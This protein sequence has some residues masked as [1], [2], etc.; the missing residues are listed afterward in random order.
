MNIDATRLIARLDIK[1]NNVV[2]GI[3][4]EGIRKV[5]DP[6]IL[7]KKYYD[8]GI[9]EIIYMDSV[10]SLYGRNSLKK[11]IIDAASEIFVPLTVGGG[12]RSLKDIREALNSG[13]DKVAINTQAIKT[14]SF[15]KEAAEKIG[16]QAVVVSIEAKKQNN[17]KWEAFYNN[18]RERSGKDVIIWA[19]EAQS[20]GAGE[21]LITSIDHEGLKKGMDIKLLDI[22]QKEINIPIIFSGGIGSYQSIMEVIPN[23]D[24]I[25]I[26]GSLH[27]NE[28]NISE[29]KK[30]LKNNDISV[31][32]I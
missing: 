24:A 5:G 4:L 25:A 19:Q 31:R 18:G 28:L 9:D 17:N 1:S 3:N 11:V 20:L 16:S 6:K 8:E 29:I 14:P 10:A 26:A 32:D 13:A 15:I 12:I 21:L 7:A 23:A 27:Y 2:K 22:L 30:R